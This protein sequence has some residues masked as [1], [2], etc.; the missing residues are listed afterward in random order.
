MKIKSL[1]LAL[2]FGSTI[3]IIFLL[4][5]NLNHYLKLAIFEYPL[6]DLI[7]IIILIVGISIHLSSFY[8]F[9]F[10]GKGTP[11]PIE[12]PKK[13]VFVG[14]Y[15]F[16][17]NPMYLGIFADILGGFFVFGHLLLLVYAFLFLV[18]IHLYVVFVEEPKL[19][20]RFGRIYEEYTKSVPRWIPK[21]VL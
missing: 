18:F 4:F 8:F 6:L 10:I 15:K 1:F 17:R 7:G 16:V 12:P 14:L 19:K 11:V 20:E 5:I 2:L 21:I 9:K 3:I 13:L